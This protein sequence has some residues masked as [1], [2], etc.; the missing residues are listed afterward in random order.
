[1]EE[2]HSGDSSDMVTKGNL[3]MADEI[4]VLFPFHLCS[5][6]LTL[7]MVSHFLVTEMVFGDKMASPQ[8]RPL[9]SSLSKGSVPQAMNLITVFSPLGSLT[10]ASFALTILILS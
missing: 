2:T 5:L 9:G 1:M 6:E 4:L 8:S 10:P 7:S 3:S